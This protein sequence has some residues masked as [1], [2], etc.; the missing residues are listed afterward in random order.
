MRSFADLKLSPGEN[1]VPQPAVD[2]HQ[3]I[4]PESTA[5][6]ARLAMRT[7]FAVP[8]LRLAAFVNVQLLQVNQTREIHFDALVAIE[9]HEALPDDSDQGG[10][11]HGP[12]DPELLQ[13]QESRYRVRRMQRGHH[14]VAGHRGVK[15]SQGCVGV[16]NLAH[17]DD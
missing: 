16:P 3:L 5:A 9:T 14:Q 1:G 8:E 17:Q 6:A 11:E 10:C 15:S 13:T 4:Q 2:F 12:C 7:T